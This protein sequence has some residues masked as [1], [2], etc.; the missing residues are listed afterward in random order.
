MNHVFELHPVAERAAGRDHRILES[1]AGN[2][3]TQVQRAVGGGAH[4]FVSPGVG[5]FPP[6]VASGAACGGASASVSTRPTEWLGALMPSKD[7][8]VATRST[9]STLVR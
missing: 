6:G 7:A 2:I 1:D 9:G 4:G 8:S 3:D 5:C